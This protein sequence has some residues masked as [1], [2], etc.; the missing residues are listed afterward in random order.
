MQSVI[1]VQRGDTE[2]GKHQVRGV[3]FTDQEP[4]NHQ[5]LDIGFFS[6]SRIVCGLKRAKTAIVRALLSTQGQIHSSTEEDLVATQPVLD[7]EEISTPRSL[8]HSADEDYN[9]AETSPDLVTESHTFFSSSEQKNLPLSEYESLDSPFSISSANLSNKHEKDRIIKM[10]FNIHDRAAKDPESGLQ[11]IILSSAERMTKTK[12]GLDAVEFK[13]D[14]QHSGFALFTSGYK[15]FKSWNNSLNAQRKELMTT[16]GNYPP[17]RFQQFVSF[18]GKEQTDDKLENEPKG[19]RFILNGMKRWYPSTTK[20]FVDNEAKNTTYKKMTALETGAILSYANISVNAWKR[21]CRLMSAYKGLSLSASNKDLKQLT[22]RAP[23]FFTS[24]YEYEFDKLKDKERI[25][26]FVIEIPHLIEMLVAREL[27]AKLQDFPF[28]VIEKESGRPEPE[29]L[30]RFGYK[31]HEFRA[32]SA[33]GCG[34]YALFTSDHGKGASLGV[35][36]LLLE[37]S[38]ERRDKKNADYGTVSFPFYRM[39]CK[40]DP[41]EVIS[42]LSPYVNRGLKVLNESKLIAVRNQN[43]EVRCFLVPKDATIMTVEKR[44]ECVEQGR[45]SKLICRYTIASEFHCAETDVFDFDTD[46]LEFWTAIYNFDSCGIADLLFVLAAQGREGMSTA[47]CMRCNLKKSQWSDKDQEIEARNITFADLTPHNFETLGCKSL[48][49]WNFCPLKW[50]QPLM[51]ENMGMVN[52]VYFR[53]VSFLL[54]KLDSL[55]V[56]ESDNRLELEN[57]LD[58]HETKED[59]LNSFNH[60]LAFK[61]SELTKRKAEMQRQ[62]NRGKKR[63]NVQMQQNANETIISIEKVRE[64]LKKEQRELIN[65]ID[66]IADTITEIKSRLKA[67]VEDRSKRKDTLDGKIENVSSIL[68]YL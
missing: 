11:D 53:M 63:G 8:F 41:G 35:V 5:E 36:R 12:R 40:K 65:D 15:T 62:K 64:D 56:E 25:D 45:I 43:N 68:E 10:L 42:V 4:T 47:R 55:S 18:L 67:F 30:P 27:A 34:V 19:A 21:V 20:N 38:N 66:A 52:K 17:H 33:N 46:H 32:D 22:S 14:N 28:V 1:K 61:R 57:L 23:N 39:V 6:P 9:K 49:I 13:R 59:H 7:E 26:Y 2:G 29:H 54:T 37:T 50:L 51:H 60:N 48:P 3:Y 44:K 16:T 58:L 31:T 24:Y